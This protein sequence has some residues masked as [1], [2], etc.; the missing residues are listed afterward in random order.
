MTEKKNTSKKII[1]NLKKIIIFFNLFN[2][3]LNIEEIASFLSFKIKRN[4]LEK[5]LKQNFA[6]KNKLFFLKKTIKKIIPLTFKNKKISQKFIK[7]A[8]YWLYFLR[9][10]PFI[11]GISICNTTAFFCASEK[12]DIDLLVIAKK[13]RIWTCRIIVTFLLHLL[14]LRRHGKKIGGRFCLSFF[15]DEENL[16]LKK[17]KLKED[18]FLAFWTASQIPLWGKDVFQKLAQQNKA[19]IKKEVGIDILF[20]KNLSSLKETSNNKFLEKIFNSILEKLL[21]KIFFKR[22]WQKFQKLKDKSGTIIS[23]GILKFHDKDQRKN[24]ALKYFANF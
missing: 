21:K 3:A 5:I 7:K 11:K 16:N 9:F 1:I 23:D 2:R 8:Q 20:H 4:T 24:I 15:I 19:W 6:Y 18:P 17:I 10:F 14:G 12:S 22:T 13:N